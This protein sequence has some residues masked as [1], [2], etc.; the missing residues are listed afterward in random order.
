[1]K[2][3]ILKVWSHFSTIFT[4]SGEVLRQIKMLFGQNGDYTD[5]Q[6]FENYINCNP[7]K[8]WR[9][10]PMQGCHL[11]NRS[12]PCCKCLIIGK[13]LNFCIHH[14]WWWCH[15]IIVINFKKLQIFW[16]PIKRK[17]HLYLLCIQTLF[18]VRGKVKA[19]TYLFLFS[20]RCHQWHQLKMLLNIFEINW[21]WCLIP[22]C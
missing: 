13:S 14:F 7:L 10:G 18:N 5:S 22:A 12:N 11:H 15:Y 19:K 4:I 8:G 2:F 21:F 17:C 16:E 6:C 20:T 1:M 9:L 3:V